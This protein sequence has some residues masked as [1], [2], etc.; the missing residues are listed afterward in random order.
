[1]KDGLQP[2]EDRERGSGEAMQGAQALHEGRRLLPQR[3]RRRPL[4]LRHLPQEHRR[5]AR[6]LRPGRGSEPSIALQR[7]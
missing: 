5:R 3:L 7:Q 2:I 4:R 6:R 1:L